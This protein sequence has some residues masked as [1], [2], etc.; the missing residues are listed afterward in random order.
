MDKNKGIKISINLGKIK[1]TG[2]RYSSNVLVSSK[3]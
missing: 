3:Q 2:G 1:K